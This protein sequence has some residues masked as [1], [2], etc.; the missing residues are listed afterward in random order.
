MKTTTFITSALFGALAVAAPLKQ[1]ALRT[2]TV[3]VLETVTS[4]YTQ[5]EGEAKTAAPPPAS[6]PAYFFENQA[7]PTTTKAAA[8][9]YTPEPVKP[10]SVYT[11]PPPP[12]S[13]SAKA[14]EYTP[15]PPPPSSAAPAPSSVYTPP[16]APA[17]SAAPA[18]VASYPATPGTGSG[19]GQ[20]YNSKMT[21]YDI[22]PGA[23]GS[24]SI[25]LSD[26][27]PVVALAKNLMGEPIY[28]KQTGAGIMTNCG[29]KIVIDYNG[30]KTTATILDTC[31]G[32]E[33][34]GIDLT[35]SLW[36][37]VVGSGDPGSKLPVKWSYA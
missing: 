17:S 26:D 15:A 34:N 22:P 13:S 23:A 29:K 33:D 19:N 14:P 3:T 6:T 16:P 21:V 11:P 8:P 24:C 32:C 18:P 10:S 25:T 37:T 30:K 35:R 5:W 27:M 20:V 12:P 2:T 1:R 31:P 36:A 4:Y 9:A 7:K 28:D